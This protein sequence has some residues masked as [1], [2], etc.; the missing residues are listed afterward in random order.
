MSITCCNITKFM[1][2][3]LLAITVILLLGFSTQAFGFDP[4]ERFEYKLTWGFIKA[5][6][7]SMELV[8]TEEGLTI[9][10]TAKSSDWIT[11]FY[12]VKNI[13]TS[14]VENNENFLPLHYHINTREGKHRKDKEVRFLHEE[15]VAKFRD[16]LDGE[17][18]TVSIPPLIYDPLSIFYFFRGLDLVVGQTINVPLFDSKEVWDVKVRVI[19]KE[20]VRTPAGKFRA[21][22]VKPEL[23]SEGIFSRKGEFFI[24]ITDDERRLPV[25]IATK[26]S[27]GFIKATLTGGNY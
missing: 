2:L 17:E 3:G 27:F 26:V 16:N 25:K 23:K 14:L 6:T 19:K 24:W 7:S 5:G 21:I 15:G 12:P 22:K 9:V 10:S 4:P 8:E 20:T 11:T 1:R 13:V 18:L